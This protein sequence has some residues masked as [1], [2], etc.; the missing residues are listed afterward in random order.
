MRGRLQ[1]Q[2]LLFLSTLLP[3]QHPACYSPTLCSTFNQTSRVS[4]AARPCPSSS[5]SS[6]FS[7]SPVAAEVFD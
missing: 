4:P 3:L 2:P 1:L 6:F 5:S 7:S